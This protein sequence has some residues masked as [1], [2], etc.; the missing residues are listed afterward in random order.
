VA[1]GVGPPGGRASAALRRGGVAHEVDAGVSAVAHAVVAPTI[2]A[3]TVVASALLLK[4]R[5]R[6][7]Q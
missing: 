6:Q 4:R 7:Q 1:E 3:A 2:I 5:S